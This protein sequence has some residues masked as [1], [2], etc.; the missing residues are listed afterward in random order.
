MLVLFSSKSKTAPLDNEA[1]LNF[2]CWLAFPGTALRNVRGLSARWRLEEENEIENRKQIEAGSNSPS[3]HF[4]PSGEEHCQQLTC[5]TVLVVLQN[6]QATMLFS[7]A[8][9]R[10]HAGEFKQGKGVRGSWGKRS[11]IPNTCLLLFYWT[12]LHM[13]VIQLPGNRLCWATAG[14]QH[15]HCQRWVQI[16]E[17]NCKL[18]RW[19]NVVLR[20]Q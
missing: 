9:K 7:K 14:H 17:S 15:I 10:K 6:C 11:S 20:L 16:E 13:P 2:E 12:V 3:Y 18:A 8:L 1:I 4:S 19:V 5:H